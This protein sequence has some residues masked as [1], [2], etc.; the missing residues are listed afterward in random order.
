MNEYNVDAYNYLLKY[1]QSII[2]I[3]EHIYSIKDVNSRYI[4]CSEPFLKFIQKKKKG[5][6]G[7]YDYDLPWGEYASLYREIDRQTAAS[8]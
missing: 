6:I 8:R 1:S 4:D 5:I 2:R 7:K 3:G